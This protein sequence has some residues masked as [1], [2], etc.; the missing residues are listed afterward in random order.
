M[1]S[2]APDESFSI[3]QSSELSSSKLTTPADNLRLIAWQV[4]SGAPLD[5]G[6]RFWRDFAKVGTCILSYVAFR[7]DT[8]QQFCQ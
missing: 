5:K 6:Q 8:H 3:L 7:Q 1:Q 4:S 2:A